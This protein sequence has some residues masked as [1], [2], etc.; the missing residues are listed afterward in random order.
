[1]T[2]TMIADAALISPQMIAVSNVVV[3]SQIKKEPRRSPVVGYLVTQ[4]EIHHSD[5]R[6]EHDR[7]ANIYNFH[8]APYAVCLMVSCGT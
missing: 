6:R 2:E 1:M 5:V 7:Y 8:I 3:L 4:R